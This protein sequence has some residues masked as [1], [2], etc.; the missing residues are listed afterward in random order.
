MTD[1]PYWNEVRNTVE[2]D[3]TWGGPTARIYAFDGS[4]Y[5]DRHDL[6]G[7]YAWTISDPAT[8]AFVAEHA[9]ARVLDPMAG[10]GY[11]AYL[12]SATADVL[13]FD[14]NPPDLGGNHW[15]KQGVIHAPVDRGDAIEVA[16]RHGA[17]RTLLLAWPPYDDPTGASVVRAYGGARIVYIGESS[18][19]C[20]GDDNLFDEFR[21]NW[22][23]VAEHR[24]VQY[25]GMH[26]FVIV[27]D[28]KA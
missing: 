7:R 19:G 8:V 11:W 22:V 20:C 5:A 26:D 1:N 6:V 17:G 3:R 25:T 4:P 2:A 27:Y 13:A 14:L 9:G 23:K 18:G 24:P 10:S 21:S 15:H 28:R 12:L 16:D